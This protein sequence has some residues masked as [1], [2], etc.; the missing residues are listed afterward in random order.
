MTHP[1]TSGFPPVNS[2][3]Q[4]NSPAINIKM[5]PSQLSL[6]QENYQ[7]SELDEIEYLDLLITEEWDYSHLAHFDADRI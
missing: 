6:I 3:N 2:P 5:T 7:K 4:L 1:N